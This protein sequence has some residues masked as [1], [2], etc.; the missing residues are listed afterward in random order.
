MPNYLKQ[1]KAIHWKIIIPNIIVQM[2]C[3]SYV[4][5]SYAV[6]VKV[7]SFR[8]NLLVLF[9][10]QF[11][12]AA[13]IVLMN[14]QSRSPIIIPAL[15][16]SCFFAFD[17]LWHGN[18]MAAGLLLMVPLCLFLIFLGILDQPAES[19]WLTFSLIY[20][21]AIPLVMIRLTAN[22]VTL[23]S[24]IA[25]LPMVTII[26]FCQSPL[27]LRGATYHLLDSTIAAVIAIVLILAMRP[28]KWS[29][30]LAIL[31][32]VGGWFLLMRYRH[33]H[34][35]PAAINFYQM[36]LLIFVYWH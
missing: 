27:A 21:L 1:L 14:E 17:G 23:S 25:L 30:L 34:I 16:A 5:A 11:F 32:I 15:I 31:L 3:W 18:V 26:A 35:S 8:G 7:S 28:F 4:A 36:L 6:N 12:T 24:V 9:I 10:Y 19:K 33:L 13:A 20:S 22:F 2:I 29:I